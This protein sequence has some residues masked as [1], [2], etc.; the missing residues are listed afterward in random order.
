M[1]PNNTF[2]A[3]NTQYHKSTTSHHLVIWKKMALE[4]NELEENGVGIKMALEERW[5]WKKKMVIEISW[6]L[7]IMLSST[8][9]AMCITWGYCFIRCS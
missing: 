5:S 7:G 9:E 2:S 4:E 6:W 8:S 3:S 1:L